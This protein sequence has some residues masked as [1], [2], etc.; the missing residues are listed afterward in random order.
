[1]VVEVGLGWLH[2]VVGRVLAR[3][4]VVVLPSSLLGRE[5]EAARTKECGALS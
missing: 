3:L 4:H 2:G 1:M 5:L